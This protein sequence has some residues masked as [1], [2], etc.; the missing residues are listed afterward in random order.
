[1]RYRASKEV[2]VGGRGEGSTSLLPCRLLQKNGRERER[3]NGFFF[4]YFI[5]FFNLG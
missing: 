1:M 2:D 4:L 3:G 5:L